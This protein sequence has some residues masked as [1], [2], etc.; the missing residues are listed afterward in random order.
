M[1]FIKLAIVLQT[2]KI[3][4][5]TYKDS[6]HWLSLFLIVLISICYTASAVVEIAQ[7]VPREKIWNPFA[8]GVCVDENALVV[9]SGAV[10]I[11]ID[12]LLLLLP[13]YA[14]L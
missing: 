12:F 9:A 14:I 10:N 1:L 6:V 2:Q 5:G 13:I 7:Y 8:S 4:R 11:G 3:F